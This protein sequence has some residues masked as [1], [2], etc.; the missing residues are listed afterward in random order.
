MTKMVERLE[1]Q[2]LEEQL[3]SLGLF[4]LEKKVLRG[5]LI[6]VYNILSGGQ[7]RARCWSPF[8]GYQ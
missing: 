1:G 8:S 4:S 3:D 7:R 6:P 5:D 2:I